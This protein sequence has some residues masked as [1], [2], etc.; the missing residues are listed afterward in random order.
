MHTIAAGGADGWLYDQV[1]KGGR[2][3]V[4][5]VVHLHVVVRLCR[6]LCWCVQHI[7]VYMCA[8]HIHYT[9][10]TYLV[11]VYLGAGEPP[12]I[13]QAALTCKWP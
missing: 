9:H 4:M 8:L 3:K 2:C 10:F 13:L 1:G 11:M 7:Q 12:P 6:F 5:V